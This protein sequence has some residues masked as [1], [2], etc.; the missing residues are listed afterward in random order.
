MIVFEVQSFMLVGQHTT[1]KFIGRK[2]ADLPIHA[3][4]AHGGD[5][6]MSRKILFNRSLISPEILFVRE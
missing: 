6:K 1:K 3:I 2:G 4:F 5:R